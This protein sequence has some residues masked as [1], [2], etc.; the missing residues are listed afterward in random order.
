VRQGSLDTMRLG[1]GLSG[2]KL[3]IIALVVIILV[4]GGVF[5]GMA[6]AHVPTAKTPS[7]SISSSYGGTSS[8]SGGSSSSSGGSGYGWG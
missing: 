6:L 8:S 2:M 7:T 5:M 3:G 4:V 1:K